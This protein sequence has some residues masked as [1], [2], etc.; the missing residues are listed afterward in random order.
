MLITRGAGRGPAGRTDHRSTPSSGG[1]SGRAHLGPPGGVASDALHVASLAAPALRAGLRPEPA[2]RAV[3]HLRILTGAAGL[4]L[5]GTERVL[6]WDGW[7]SG[8]AA[9][10]MA[11]ARFPLRDGRTH[12]L[13]A[14]E[15][16]CRQ[17]GCRLGTAVAAPLVVDGATVGSLVAFADGRER[18]RQRSVMEVARW[19]S[20]QL[21]LAELDDS[22]ARLAEAEL[23][24]MRLQ[25]SPHFV[26]NCLTTIA[27]FVRTDPERARDLLIDFA[28]FARYAFRCSRDLTTLADEL[29]SV[30]RYLVLERARFGDRL[31]F[32]LQVAPEVLSVTVPYLS[33]QPLVENAI[34]HGVQGK[35]GTGRVTVVAADAGAEAHI[36]V[37]DDG[38]GMDPGH[39]RSVLSGD[40]GPNAGIGLVNVDERLRQVYGEGH[41]LIVETALG[42]GTKVLLRVPKYHPGVVPG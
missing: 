41:G 39:L 35:S 36:S 25:I 19:V 40:S 24:A 2:R 31:Q 21:E 37:E 30:D 7:H 15:A 8:H 4:A 32:S 34:R 22:R 13:S 29:R 20:G 11:A 28:G 3:R 14:E 10:A 23:R 5:T 9:A 27:S 6:A 1:G 18:L 33:L 38:V 42:A 26:Y 12:V 16:A 17:P